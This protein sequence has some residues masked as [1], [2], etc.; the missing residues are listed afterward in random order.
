MPKITVLPNPRY[1]PEGAEFEMATGE[2]LIRGLLSHGVKIEHA[3]EMSC[4]CSTCHVIIRKGFDSLE[5]PSDKEY[6]CL[7]KAWGVGALSR[8]S[9]QVKVADEDLTIEVPKY[10]RNQVS[11]DD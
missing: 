11:E 8:L 1:C 4:A 2:N 10:T 6:D 9:C 5:E 7:D 3:C